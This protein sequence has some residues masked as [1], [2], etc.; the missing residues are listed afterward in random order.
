MSEAIRRFAHAIV[1][2]DRL[3]NP[4][5]VLRRRIFGIGGTL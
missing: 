1:A 2:A 5:H 3:G 4:L